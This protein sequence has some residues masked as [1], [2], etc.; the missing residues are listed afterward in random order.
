MPQNSIDEKST[1]FQAMVPNS[2]IA[3]TKVDFSSM[4][5]LSEQVLTQIF[6][7]IWHH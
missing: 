6:V 5:F 2:T 3:W 7:P 1:L 4:E